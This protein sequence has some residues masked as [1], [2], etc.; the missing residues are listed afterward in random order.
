M[1]YTRGPWTIKRHTSM[2]L[3]PVGIVDRDDRDIAQVYRRKNRTS[4]ATET[5]GNVRIIE[6]SPDLYEKTGEFLLALREPLNS[7]AQKKLE[8]L[9]ALMTSISGDQKYVKYHKS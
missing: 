4:G 5:S 6:S 9:E 7:D 1:M 3:G 2:G 8:E